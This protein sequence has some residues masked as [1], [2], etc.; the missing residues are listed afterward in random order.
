M[1]FCSNSLSIPGPQPTTPS[2]P[3]GGDNGV[4]GIVFIVLL[5]SLLAIYFVG[6]GL[7]YRIR[8]E[9]RGADLIAHRT[10]WI[11]LPGYARDGVVYVFR[12]IAN[13]GADPYG[14]V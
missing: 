9:K 6:F 13:K 14:A 4:G 12:R 10:F 11:A 5:L 7:F 2:S 1:K 8:Q 3:G